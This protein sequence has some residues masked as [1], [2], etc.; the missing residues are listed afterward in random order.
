ML[1]AVLFDLDGTLLD[2]LPDIRASLNVTL[3]KFGYPEV[4]PEQARLYV[5]NGAK[6]LVERALPQGAPDLEE[7]YEDFRARYAQSDNSLTRLY[8]GEREVLSFLVGRGVKLAVITN[9]PQE[10]TKKCVE[11]FFPRSLFSFVAGD[12]GLFP[13]KP[14]PALAR[15]CAL[16]LRVSPAEC[17]FVGD[18]ETDVLTAKNAGMTGIAVLWGYRSRERLEEAGANLFCGSFPELGKIFEKFV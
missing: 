1:K 14:D 7:V 11:Q 12:S 3:Q 10:A 4:T 16:S 2:T 18:G 9:K 6:K 13:C 17:A 8:E 15:Y 5:G